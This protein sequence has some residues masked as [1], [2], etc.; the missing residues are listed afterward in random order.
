[1]L[2]MKGSLFQFMLLLGPLNFHLVFLNGP[3]TVAIPHLLSHVKAFHWR[4]EI[5]CTQI[6]PKIKQCHI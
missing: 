2:M 4:L 3:V 6:K 1:M 5:N